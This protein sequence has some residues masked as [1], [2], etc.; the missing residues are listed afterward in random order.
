MQVPYYRGAGTAQTMNQLT[1]HQQSLMTHRQNTIANRQARRNMAMSANSAQP[2]QQGYAAQGQS[3]SAKSTPSSG[4]SDIPVTTGDINM[5]NDYTPGMENIANAFG[6]G[7]TLGNFDTSANQLRDRINGLANAQNQGITN[8]ALSRGVGASGFTQQ[9]MDQTGRDALSAYG[10]GLSDLADKFE[11]KRLAAGQLQ[12]D[13]FTK[14]MTALDQRRQQQATN[15]LSRAS[16]NQQGQIARSN[17]SL[18]LGTQ[19]LQN[20]ALLLGQK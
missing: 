16:I 12:G 13:L 19:A 2:S 9:R 15:D 20:L 3:F 14:L 6:V 8:D 17:Y 4:I 18:G 11:G 10:T 7:S 5:N 1:P